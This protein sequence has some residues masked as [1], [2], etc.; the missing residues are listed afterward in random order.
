MCVHA[1]AHV[2]ICVH[3]LGI[4]P[5]S[6]CQLYVIMFNK[7][8]VSVAHQI[9][10]CSFLLLTCCLQKLRILSFS[11]LNSIFLILYFSAVIFFF[12][13]QTQLIDDTSLKDIGKKLLKLVVSESL[14]TVKL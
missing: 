1:H 7:S 5:L 14:Q 3:V 12:L 8:F 13:N 9:D 2:C 6:I 4:T 11:H 10:Y